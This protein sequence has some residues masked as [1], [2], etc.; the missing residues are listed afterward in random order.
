M[1][2]RIILYFSTE[3]G[4]A[5]S[6]TSVQIRVRRIRKGTLIF[7]IIEENRMGAV[8]CENCGKTLAEEQVKYGD[9]Q[10]CSLCDD[11]VVNYIEKDCKACKKKEGA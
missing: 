10:Q 8:A 6:G 5:K 2:Y 4:L 3:K 7:R 9:C 1:L 11:C